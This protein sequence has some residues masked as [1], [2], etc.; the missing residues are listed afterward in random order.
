MA[1]QYLYYITLHGST[2]HYIT[3]H[4]ITL[5]YNTLHHM[6]LYGNILH[7]LDEGSDKALASSRSNPTPSSCNHHNHHATT[8]QPSCNHHG[9]ITWPPCN[10]PVT[11]KWPPG[12][13]TMQPPFLSLHFN[14]LYISSH[15]IRD[16]M[17]FLHYITL[18]YRFHQLTIRQ[19]PCNHHATVM[20]PAWNHHGT[21]GQLAC[22]HHATTM[23]HSRNRLVTIT[24]S[25]GNHYVT[26]M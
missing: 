6:A 22:H 5:Y 8:M 4:Y 7:R 25:P 24:Q 19:P 9:I 26:I 14:S 3:L 10:H 21:I 13:G 15:H 17:R 12:E 23:C 2:L 18:R 1:L 16:S 20:Q 11:T